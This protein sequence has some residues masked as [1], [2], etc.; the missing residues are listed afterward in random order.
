[1]AWYIAPTCTHS[2]SNLRIIACLKFSVNSNHFSSM[3]LIISMFTCEFCNNLFCF[4]IAIKTIT[5]CARKTTII[6]S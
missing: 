1:M 5:E 2:H 6:I 4:G 3:Q